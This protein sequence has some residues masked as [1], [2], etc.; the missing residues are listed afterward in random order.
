MQGYYENRSAD[1]SHLTGENRY[2]TKLF[3]LDE[4][5]EAEHIVRI[6]DKFV[7]ILNLEELGFAKATPALVGRPS[8]DPSHMLKLY[9]YGYESGVRSSRKLER[10]TKE[11][12]PAMWLMD[13]LTP[14]FK[15]I[16]DFRKDNIT[17][18]TKVFYEYGLFLDGAG[19]FGKKTLA[20]DSTKI[21]ANNNKKTNFSKKKIESRIRYGKERVV[22]YLEALEAADSMEEYEAVSEKLV[23]A[24]KQIAKYEEY[25]DRLSKAGEGELSEV[26]PDARLMGNNKNGVDVSYNIQVVTDKENHLVAEFD[27]SMSP[28]DH[29]QLASMMK[30]TQETLRKKDI[31]GIADKGYYNAD[32]LSQCEEAKAKVIVSRQYSP[33]EKHKDKS[34]H[35][36]KFIYDPERDVYTCPLGHILPAHNSKQAKRRKFFDKTTCQHCEHKSQ[37]LS[38]KTK[39]RV[40]NRGP[41]ADLFDRADKMYLDNLDLYKL[42][43]Q[44][45]EHVFGT[46][47]RTMNGGYF[48]LRTKEKVKCETSLM[49]LGYNLK[50]SR[51][52]LGFDEIMRRLDKYAEKFGRRGVVSLF[53]FL[54]TSMLFQKKQKI[55][56]VCFP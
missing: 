50:R 25:K 53:L 20:I 52:V 19:L 7:S 24:E 49:L 22:E 2:Q 30:K 35:L 16:A 23:K 32:Q 8:Y 36:D 46:L 39:F 40:I 27:T 15:T 55:H 1:M 5:I 42:R 13:E 43:Q 56:A 31:V 48:L 38:G 3:N 41:N 47:K 17:P 37:C 28:T 51:N 21:K 33:G 45:V 6:I 54:L 26:D 18:L 14:D 29:D 11:S 10:L 44:I 34:F 9:L 12:L 4:R